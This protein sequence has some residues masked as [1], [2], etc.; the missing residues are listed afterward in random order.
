MCLENLKYQQPPLQSSVF[1]L[2]HQSASLLNTSLKTTGFWKL[3]KLLN[4]NI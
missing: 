2:S 1:F 4:V 3:L